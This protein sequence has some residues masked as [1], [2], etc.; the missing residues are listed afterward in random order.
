MNLTR[1]RTPLA[2]AP[3]A[4]LLAGS[5]ALLPTSAV[6]APTEVYVSDGSGDVAT[7]GTVSQRTKD[8]AD[9]S[10]TEV[11]RSEESGR[12]VFETRVSD[13]APLSTDEG[14]TV[15]RVTLK[16]VQK[17]KTITVK[18]KKKKVRPKPFKMILTYVPNEPVNPLTIQSNKSGTMKRISC[19]DTFASVDDGYII[20]E[21]YVA[22]A[23]SCF[24]KSA[25]RAN[26]SVLVTSYENGGGVAR[27]GLTLPYFALN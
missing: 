8:S 10:Y 24:G 9:I 18:G 7:E 16:V 20:Y 27:D 12:V 23:P 25:E 2:A 19:G 15:L 26:G 3:I 21:A 1:L 11:Y 5:L 22:L 4:A 6:A 14:T 13:G 17:A